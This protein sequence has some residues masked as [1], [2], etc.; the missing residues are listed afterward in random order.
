[1]GDSEQK[2]YQL[3]SEAEKKLNRSNGFFGQLFG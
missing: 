1:M 3:I 2:A